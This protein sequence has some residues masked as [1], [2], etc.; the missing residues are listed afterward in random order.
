MVNSSEHVNLLITPYNGITKIQSNRLDSINLLFK[1]SSTLWCLANSMHIETFQE[2]GQTFGM[3]EIGDTIT[4]S[5]DK[6]V[7][8]IQVNS[9]KAK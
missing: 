9:S 8:K 7:K 2:N 5:F 3:L 6:I 1:D 4:D